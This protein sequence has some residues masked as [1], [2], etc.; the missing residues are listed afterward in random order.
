MSNLHIKGGRLID[1]KSRVDA[2][3]DIFVADG[4]IAEDWVVTEALGIFQQLGIVADTPS[5]LA[6]AAR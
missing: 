3:Q 4:K 5:L 6:S 2:K 1:P